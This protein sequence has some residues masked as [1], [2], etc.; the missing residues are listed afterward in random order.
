MSRSVS[1]PPR[2]GER[3]TRSTET[4]VIERIQRPLKAAAAE[5]AER[6]DRTV[7]WDDIWGQLSGVRRFVASI[8]LIEILAMAFAVRAL[9]V[10]TAG[11][12]LN[13][14][15]LFYVFARDIQDH[16]YILPAFS[17]YN[18]GTIPFA[19][20]PLG[21]YI[22]ALVDNLTPLSL[23]DAVWLLPMVESVASVAA[24]WF[25][26]KL[27]LRDRWTVIL[28]TV[29]FA[30]VPR[31]FLWLIMGG[32]LTRAL[33]LTL[34][35]LAIHQARIAVTEERWQPAARASVLIGLCVLTTLE[36]A[37]WLVLSLPL[38]TLFPLQRRRFITLGAIGLGAVAIVL[39]W[40]VLIV[41]RHG[42]DPFLAAREYGG[43]AIGTGDFVAM[44][45]NVLN[46]LHTGEPFFPLIAALGL[47]GATYAI[48]RGEWLIP[49][50][51]ILTVIMGTRAFPTLA[52]LPTAMLAA[53]AV[54]DVIIPAYLRASGGARRIPASRKLAAAAVGGIALFFLIGAAL[55]DTRGDQ[56][57]LRPL[58]DNELAAMTWISEETPPDAEF[59]VISRNGWFADRDGEWFPALAERENIATVQGYEWVDGEFERRAELQIMSQMCLPGAG[60]CLGQLLNEESFDYVY[61]PETC[62]DVLRELLDAEWRYQVIFDNGAT[63][64]QRVNG[65]VRPGGADAWSSLPDES[66]MKSSAGSVNSEGP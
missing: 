17:T 32:G 46:P 45:N 57:Y 21:F 15:G 44:W 9:Y 48:V 30:L 51:W 60:N 65:P 25:L 52:V 50:W 28:A 27:L 2:P 59:L 41:A 54:R 49:G 58:T 12:P 35:I 53:M 55:D 36:T 10:L 20:P 34:A 22:A 16:N 47:L 29:A 40:F 42:L 64:F 62:C 39:P 26:A 31:S 66:E 63:V 6:G 56:R 1:D 4:T 43:S 38:F 7:T 19:Y 5:V 18:D 33:A 23:L 61:V 14:G 37:S 8:G 13:D 24:F 11:F 3:G